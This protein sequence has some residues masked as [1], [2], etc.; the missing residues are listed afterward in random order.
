MGKISFVVG[1]GAGYVLGS[2]AGRERYESIASAAR[3]VKDSPAIQEVAGVIGAQ[4]ADL[5]ET[6]KT[7]VSEGVQARVS[8]VSQKVRS[9]TG[10]KSPR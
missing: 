7:K 2:R 4:A 1:L 8:T 9:V 6:A 5:K 10:E 3:Q